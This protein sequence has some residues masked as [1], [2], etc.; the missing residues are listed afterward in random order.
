LTS[1]EIGLNI[2]PA[3]RAERLPPGVFRDA[4]D[5][6]N[7]TPSSFRFRP[8]EIK[9]FVW[10]FLLPKEGFVKRIEYYRKGGDT[11]AVAAG[12]IDL[13]AGSFILPFPSARFSPVFG[14]WPGVSTHP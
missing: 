1:F 7:V 12:Q 4:T 3:G 13:V 10:L 6:G 2:D 14:V 11:G 9:I 5:R 8:Y